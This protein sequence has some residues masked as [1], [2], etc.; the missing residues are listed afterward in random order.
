MFSVSHIQAISTELSLNNLAIAT[1]STMTKSF[2]SAL[3]T[4]FSFDWIIDSLPIISISIHKKKSS[5][6]QWYPTISHVLPCKS[7]ALPLPPSTN[8]AYHPRS[9]QSSTDAPL[10]S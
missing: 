1:M 5:S 10:N 6:N 9:Y 8:D 3:M 2:L 7:L 4:S